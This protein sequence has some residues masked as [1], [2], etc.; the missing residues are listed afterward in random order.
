MLGLQL[1]RGNEMLAGAL[2]PCFLVMLS[3]LLL[4]LKQDNKV[5]YN[6]TAQSELLEDNRAINGADVQSDNKYGRRVIGISI[7]VSALIITGLGLTASHGIGIITSVGA[8][9]SAI[10]IFIWLKNKS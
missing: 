8:F 2:V 1:S 9:I 5:L 7:T 6:D 4:L 10:G 3:E